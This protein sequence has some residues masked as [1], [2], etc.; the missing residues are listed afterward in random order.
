MTAKKITAKKLINRVVRFTQETVAPIECR[1]LVCGKDVF[2]ELG[3]CPECIKDVVFNNGK[4]CPRCGV[5]I[6]GD[7]D[8][9]G[10]CAFDKMYFDRA[11]S[12]FSYERAVQQAIL[13]MKFNNL[14]SYARV[15]AKYLVY[16]VHKHGISFD[17]VTFVPMSRNRNSI[18]RHRYNQS[19]LLAQHFC[20]ILNVDDLL[21]DAIVKIKETPAQE[22]LGRADR[23]T[24]LVGAYKVNP[25]AKDAIKGKRVLVIDDVKTTGATLNE[26]AKVLKGAGATEV[27]GITVAARTENFNY[28]IE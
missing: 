12:A 11:Y 1:C 28:E 4:T 2:D 13:S 7:E 3:F 21:V 25:N 6:D 20:A 26:C 18:R 22:S 27:I 15:F 19:K 14:G 24:N 23:K 10:N 16:L 8:Y 17:L 5:A 9:C